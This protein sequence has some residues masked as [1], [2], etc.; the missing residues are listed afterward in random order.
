MGRPSNRVAR[1]ADL[2]SAFARVLAAHGYAGATV[3]AVAAEA[4]VAPGLVHH[5]F[6]SK[7]ELLGALL[8]TLVAGFRRRLEHYAGDDDLLAY[9]DGALKLDERA[10]ITA[11]RCWVGLFAEAIRNP[12]LFRQVRRLIDAEIAAI[13]RRSGYALSAH[14][15][16][17]VLAYIIGALVMGAFAPQKSAGF[18]APG[19][20]RLIAALRAGPAKR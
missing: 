2:L 9:A 14:E 12:T 8:Q 18:A 13:E 15:A 1:R 6:D 16:S 10:D 5:H 20:K 7:E 4:G 17:A 19:L 3:A 11:A